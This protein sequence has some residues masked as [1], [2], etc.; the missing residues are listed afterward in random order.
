MNKNNISFQDNSKNGSKSDTTTKVEDVVN[1]DPKGSLA[2]GASI[3]LIGLVMGALWVWLR[4]FRHGGKSQRGGISRAS[5]QVR[6]YLN[7]RLLCIPP[8]FFFFLSLSFF[9]N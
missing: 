9:F 1:Q 5:G 6:L 3:T 2:A 7:N 4:F 8:N